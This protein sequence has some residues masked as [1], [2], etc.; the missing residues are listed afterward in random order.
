MTQEQEK[1][2]IEIPNADEEELYLEK[3]VFGD[4]EGFSNNLRN[5][6]NLY[7]EEDHGYT[8]TKEFHFSDSEPDEY[9]DSMSK[10]KTLDFSDVSDSEA[11]ENDDE[12][13]MMNDDELFMVDSDA[14]D[15]EMN[16]VID[17]NSNSN[18]ESE[19]DFDSD[20]SN[21]WEDSDDDYL[22]VSLLSSDKLRK[23]RSAEDENKIDGSLYIN[24]LRNQFERIYPIPDWAS[25]AKYD[26]NLDSDSDSNEN[27][28]IPFMDKVGGAQE[29]IITSSSNPL[30]NFLQEHQTYNLTET[31]KRLLNPE[32]INISRLVD[33]NIKKPSRAAI[34]CINF[35]PTQ[36]LILT[37]GFDRTL[38]VY[39]VDGK[40]N[41]IITSLH[42]R[43]SPVQTC[44]FHVDP[45]S[46]LTSILTGGR[47]KF[48]YKW[49][50][51]RSIIEK[52][53][54]MY[55]HEK[56]QRSFEHFKLSRNNRYIAL[57]G[58][59]GWV[60][61]LDV[62]T[63]QLVNGFK[64]EGTLQ[65]FDFA[66]NGSL[67][68]INQA[69]EIWEFSIETF[70][71]INRWTDITGLGITKLRISPN[72]RYIAVGSN[73]GFVNVYDR[74]KNNTLIK[75][76]DNLVTT[77]SS[78]E[79]S[80]D[81]QVMAIASRDKRDALKLVHLPSC[82]VFKNWPTNATPLGKVTSVAFAPTGGLLA[83]GNEQGKVRL[84]RLMDLA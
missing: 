30:M 4:A 17:S 37:G 70:T 69:G 23:L 58:N 74:L 67:I 28:N 82:K 51:D 81:S 14:E 42:L 29:T 64:I 38:R 13:A 2:K 31:D 8:K 33:A 1:D 44:S 20:T 50:V 43:Q 39:H 26:D 78:I 73:T 75:S 56:R 11:E 7:E 5:L 25:N 62:K 71:I 54:R 65:D 63:G 3:L 27:G 61:L 80:H 22:E 21:A 18:S 41:N 47:R 6:D 19:S 55:G 79:F 84:W 46:G 49:T 24:R 16:S 59:S 15:V 60:N 77:I 45:E 66:N 10:K 34:Q 12:M 52:I 36:P 9:L 53:T 32:E 76:I 68:I 72:G 40:H 57:A 83:T 35:H 48:M